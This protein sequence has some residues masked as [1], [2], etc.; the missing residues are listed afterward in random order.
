MFLSDPPAPDL[1]G[2]LYQEDRVSDGYVM[3]LTR[4]RAWRHGVLKAFAGVRGPALGAQPDA[5]VAEAASAAV[6]AAVSYGRAPAAALQ[7]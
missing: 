2:A 7:P 3:N 5:Q 1:A 6:R 4:L